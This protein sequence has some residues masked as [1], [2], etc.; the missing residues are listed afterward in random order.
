MPSVLVN[1][2][3]RFF[4]E[5]KLQANTIFT[6]PPEE[7]HHA[8]RVLRLNVDDAIE[9]LNGEFLYSAKILEVS[10]NN[11]R[12]QCQEALPSIEPKTKITLYQGMPKA[13]KL[14]YIIQKCTE[15]GV[16]GINPIIME[17]SVKK[18]NNFKKILDKSQKIAIEACKQS[19]RGKLPYIGKISTLSNLTEQ[20]QSHDLLLVAWEEEQELS[21]QDSITQANLGMDIGIVIGPEGGIDSLEIEYLKQLNAQIITFGKRILRTETAGMCAIFAILSGLNDL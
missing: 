2:M 7:A 14:F 9:L 13:E 21:L 8:S 15:I 17:R 18:G 5:E 16:Q 4:I 10:K 3:Y 12:V 6:L 19:G 20:L 1:K 11:V